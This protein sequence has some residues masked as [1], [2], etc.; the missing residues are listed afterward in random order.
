MRTV[1]NIPTSWLGGWASVNGNP[2][3]YIFQGYN[4]NYCLLA[5]C[6]D[7]E[8]ERGSFF[9]HEIYPDENGCYICIGTKR[10]RLTTED[11]SCTLHIAG[12]GDYM[13]N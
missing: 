13:Q 12:W 3:V 11:S 8:Y 2:D 4:G 10:H 5:Y 1:E 9:C 7:K 6:Y